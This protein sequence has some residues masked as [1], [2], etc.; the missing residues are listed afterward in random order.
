MG[1]AKLLDNYVKLAAAET[2]DLPTLKGALLQ[3]TGLKKDSLMVAKSIVE[4]TQHSQEK[5]T[6]F[7]TKLKKLF[8]QAHPKERLTSAVLLQRF[9]TGLRPTF[10][11][12]LLLQGN[13]KGCGRYR[14][15]LRLCGHEEQ[16]T[17]GG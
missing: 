15:C 2:G 13:D 9:V 7:A 3:R 11:L 8:K 17:M 4:R 6:D 14:V 10:G 16:T 1:E 5:A 12:Q